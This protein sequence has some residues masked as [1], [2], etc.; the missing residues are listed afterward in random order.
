M[1]SRRLTLSLPDWVADLLARKSEVLASDSD[2]MALAV[3]LSRRN[4]EHGT[5]GPFGAAVFERDTGRL[6]AAGVNL[7]PSANCS[8]A[9]AEI[10]ALSLAQQAAGDYDLG[11][12]GRPTHE[13]VTSSE[14]CAMCLGAVLWSGVRRVVCG[15]RD[16][17]VRAIG[18]D[19]G[20]KPPDWPA[21]LERR[22][23]AVVRHVMRAEA[24]AVLQ[25]YAAG[26]G[27]I[28]NARGA[29]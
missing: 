21:G 9:H 1:T 11:R 10:V 2:R 15:A 27:P 13:L 7:V 12:P 20:D 28:Y 3:E 17:D 14:P 18:L 19:E 25:A 26:G 8:S 29:E 6:V 23:I 16:E 5:G 22:G 4:I 24:A